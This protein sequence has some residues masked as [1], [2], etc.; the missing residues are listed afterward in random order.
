[1][2]RL[3]AP[4]D[5]PVPAAGV[6]PGRLLILADS[7]DPAVRGQAD[8]LRRRYEAVLGVEV[9]L[10]DLAEQEE[11]AAFRVPDKPIVE[12]L[13]TGASVYGNKLE[14]LLRPHLDWADTVLVDGGGAAAAAVGLLNPGAARLVVRLDGAQLRSGWPHLMDFTRVDDLVFDSPEDEAAALAS[15]P[16]LSADGAPHR[17]PASRLDAAVLGHTP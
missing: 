1:V 17:H 16:S 12:H 8:E 14:T 3:T 4:R 13:V 11:L 5:R 2:Q 9:R 15:L 7:G 10:L 6:S